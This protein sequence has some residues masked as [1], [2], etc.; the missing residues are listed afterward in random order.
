MNASA[1]ARRLRDLAD[2][3]EGKAKCRYGEF[4]IPV[5]L[6]DGI[7]ST[8][9][10]VYVDSISADIPMALFYTRNEHSDA[11]VKSRGGEL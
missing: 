11:Y 7:T 2:V 5:A 9:H 1:V 3:L 10:P 4:T 8:Y 6:P